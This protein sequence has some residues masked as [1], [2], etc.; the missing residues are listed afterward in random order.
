M[1]STCVRK[2]TIIWCMLTQIRSPTDIFA[3]SP[4][5]WLRKW[6]F[7]KNVKITWT[8]YPFTHMYH[9]SRSYDDVPE[10][11]ST[12]DRIFCHFGL[13][14]PPNNPENQNFEN[15]EKNSWRHYHFN[16]SKINKNHWCMIHG[17][18]STT[19]RIFSHSGPFFA[20][21]PPLTQPPPAPSPP[22]A[23]LT[24]QRTKILKKWKKQLEIS[25]FYTGVSK[26]MI[27]WCTVPEIWCAD[28]RTN[29]LEK[30][31]IEVGAPPKKIWCTQQGHVLK[32]HILIS[33]N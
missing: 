4:H 28:G 7:G 2:S 9:K 24:T 16:M 27:R 8:Y 32:N 6:K 22:P 3:L 23:N 31:H 30:W 21:L 20:L 10:I 12:T 15:T 25:S 1:S 14:F 19:D 18:W 29:G 26:I 17:I 5:D 11:L 13:F 33:W